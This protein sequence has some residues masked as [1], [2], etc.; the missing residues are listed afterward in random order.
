MPEPEHV[1][2]AKHPVYA[3]RVSDLV[4]N[5]LMPERLAVFRFDSGKPGPRLLILGA[6]HGNEICGT[7]ALARLRLELETGIV[8]LN[9][10]SL[11]MA[12]ICNPAAYRIGRRYVEANLNRIIARSQPQDYPEQAYAHQV[13]DLIDSCE[14]LLDLHS[15]HAGNGAYA[16][17]DYDTPF[18]RSLA[19]ALELPDWVTGWPAIYADQPEL[20]AGDTVQ[21]AHET[22]KHGILI[23]CG[24]HDD[25][26]APLVAYDCCLKTLAHLGMDETAETLTA[27]PP[28][29]HQATMVI[30]K[31]RPG[32]LAKPWRDLDP[33][34]AGDVLAIY[35][36]GERLLSPVT[37]TVILPH[38]GASIGTEWLYLAVP[39]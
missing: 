11:A 39:A 22:G 38:D 1:V 15:N 16:M 29:V 32:R 24:R 31:E 13:M 2:A 33:V 21:Y 17:M 5:A 14:V 27:V 26:L 28:R 35:D 10:G 25:P 18:N 3:R 36:D 23:E 37:G 30:V 7:I 19:M 8:E 9:A 6:I 20:N 4:G 12:P 34:E